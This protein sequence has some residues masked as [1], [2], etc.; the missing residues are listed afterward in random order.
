MKINKKKNIL[1]ATTK[2]REVR[3][4]AAVANS[5]FPPVVLPALKRPIV[6]AEDFSQIQSFHLH[7]NYLSSPTRTIV[8][9]LNYISIQSYNI[10]YKKNN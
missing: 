3:L 9:T 8:Y 5:D 2:G 6:A 4:S 7:T 1:L 10:S